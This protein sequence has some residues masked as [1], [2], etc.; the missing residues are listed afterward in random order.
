[1]INPDIITPEQY[2]ENSDLVNYSMYSLIKRCISHAIDTASLN[3]AKSMSLVE[4]KKIPIKISFENNGVLRCDDIHFVEIIQMALNNYS[5]AGWTIY[6]N[7]PKA[8]SSSILPPYGIIDILLIP[9]KSYAETILSVY[10]YQYM[11]EYVT[12]D[13]S[14]KAALEINNIR[15]TKKEDEN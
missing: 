15:Y 11:L 5:S 1:M 9:D 10:G 14:D 12:V 13:V 3:R 7:I 8:G 4:A 2:M 6:T